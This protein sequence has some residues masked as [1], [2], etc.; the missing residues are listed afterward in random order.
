MQHQ[1]FQL[2]KVQLQQSQLFKTSKAPKI[3]K[4]PKTPKPPKAPKAPAR[5]WD[6]SDP[7]EASWREKFKPPKIPFK[8]I[9]P[10]GLQSNANLTSD[11]SYLDI[12][13]SLFPIEL[14]KDIARES[15]RYWRQ[16]VKGIKRETW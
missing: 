8:E 16:I 15:N 5:V 1:A 7:K 10:P 4:P 3:L 9:P 11:S 6:F 12:F 14:A 2:Q 13:L